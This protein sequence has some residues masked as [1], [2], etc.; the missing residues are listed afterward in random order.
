MLMMI[1]TSLPDHAACLQSRLS[2]L[3]AGLPLCQPPCS[4]L[5]ASHLSADV[6]HFPLCCVVLLLQALLLPGNIYHLLQ[7]PTM[8]EVQAKYHN[9]HNEAIAQRTHRHQHTE[10]VWPRAAAYSAAYCHQWLLSIIRA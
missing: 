4:I 8:S 5:S 7:Q 3:L 2:M 6:L 9:E 1:A 10:Q